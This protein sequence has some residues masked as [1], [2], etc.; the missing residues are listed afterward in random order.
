MKSGQAASPP[1]LWDHFFKNFV[2][3][4]IILNFHKKLVSTLNTIPLVTKNSNKLALKS[5]GKNYMI[6]TVW[7]DFKN[8]VLNTMMNPEEMKYF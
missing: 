5:G 3:Q 1:F 4:I 7:K 2:F 6:E 8:I